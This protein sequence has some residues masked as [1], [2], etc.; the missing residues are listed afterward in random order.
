MA[1]KL[2]LTELLH[3]DSAVA[4][5]T[6]NADNSVTIPTQ[7][8]TNLAYTGTL[9]GGTGVI[10]IGSGQVYKDASGNVGIGTS[11]PSSRLQVTDTNR[12]FDTFGNLNISTSDAATVGAGGAISFSGANTTGGPSPYMFAKIQGIKEGSA[13]TYNGAL[14]F[15]TTAGNS[16]LSERM[17]IDSSGNL[18]VGTTSAGAKLTVEQ[19]GANANGASIKNQTFDYQTLGLH[20]AA[21]SGDNLLVTFVTDAASF[22]GSISYN[23]AGGLVAYNTTSDYR[24]KDISGSINN[25]LQT[26]SELKPYMGTMKGATIER[27]MFIAHETQAVAPYA[28]TGEK[29]ALDKDGNPQ[30]QQMD[31]STLVPLLTAAIQEQQ[32][33]IQDLTTR[34]TTLEGN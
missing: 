25:A 1:S 23:R 33:L 13:S 32:A 7:S 18:L 15:G 9:T 21:T 4:A 10:N 6:I 11:S 8:T 2:K 30:Y 29:D 20:N 31:H 17:R 12:I 16:A 22:R 14:L 3:P 27:P 19:S 34:L 28:V 26:V 24:A 5:I